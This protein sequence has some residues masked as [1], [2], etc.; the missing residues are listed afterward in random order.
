MFKV[1]WC[2]VCG[3]CRAQIENGKRGVLL[4]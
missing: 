2:L 1:V 4:A 3:L